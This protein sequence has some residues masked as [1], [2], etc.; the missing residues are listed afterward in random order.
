MIFLQKKPI[1]RF[2]G[3]NDVSSDTHEDLEV[4]LTSIQCYYFFTNPSKYQAP[5]TS[6]QEFTADHVLK[7]SKFSIKFGFKKN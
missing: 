7:E 2:R 5:L 3:S 6:Q 4:P 1:K